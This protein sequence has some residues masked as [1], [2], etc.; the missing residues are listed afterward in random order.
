MAAMIRPS[1]IL[2]MDLDERAYSDEVVAEI[3]RSYSY[4][5]PSVVSSHAAGEGAPENVLRLAVKL[6]RPYW[7][8]SDPAAQELWEGVMPKWLRNM[9]SKVS[10]TVVASNR[11]R[12]GQGADGLDY[13]WAEIEFGDNVLVAF[14]AASDSSVPEGAVEDIEQVRDLMTSGAFGDAKVACV[15]IPS[16]ASYEAQVAQ[17]AAEAAAAAQ[18]EAAEDEKAGEE[19]GGQT[20][21]QPSAE[22]DAPAEAV[23]AEQPAAPK[24]DA[25]RTVW[26]IEYADGSV[27]EF[28]SASGSFMS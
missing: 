19:A 25:D 1:L 2:R 8:K 23:P 5:A 6:H 24:I 21:E 16:L 10:N 12:A 9:F 11:V 14:R 22:A 27:R 28:D 26:G 15:R 7:D 13:A 17:A 20:S 18:E 4:V 3:K